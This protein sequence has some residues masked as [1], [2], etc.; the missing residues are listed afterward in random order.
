[1]TLYISLSLFKK[2]LNTTSRDEQAM[3]HVV[4][5]CSGDF[6]LQD[7]ELQT[8]NTQ[9]WNFC[10]TVDFI[11][12]F[13]GRNVY[14]WP[15]HFSAQ[16]AQW[17]GHFVG[18]RDRQTRWLSTYHIIVPPISEQRTTVLIVIDFRNTHLFDVSL[19]FHYK[20]DHSHLRSL[21]TFWYST[22]FRTWVWLIIEW[23]TPFAL[24]STCHTFQIYEQSLQFWLS[25][26]I[27]F[28]SF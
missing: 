3:N 12:I 15:Y 26:L 18:R 22:P 23:M 1:M 14:F 19:L 7:Q 4:L 20:R 17:C 21:A 13:F 8:V 6:Y 25:L 16:N 27:H 5:F 28:F 11:F 10:Y 2:M 24:V 9:P